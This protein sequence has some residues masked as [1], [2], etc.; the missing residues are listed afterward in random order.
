MDATSL[1]YL[2][3]SEVIKKLQNAGLI[4]RLDMPR[5]MR[6]DLPWRQKA[7]YMFGS[8]PLRQQDGEALRTRTGGRERDGKD[9]S[10]VSSYIQELKRE[11]LIR[12]GNGKGDPWFLPSPK[13]DLARGTQYQLH[14]PRRGRQ[15]EG[16]PTRKPR[17][18]KGGT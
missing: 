14:R 3:A 8:G 17:P 12:L 11:G 1:D 5:W 7:R 10:M 6:S 4:E 9:R 18:P 16:P 2:Q 15:S 13:N